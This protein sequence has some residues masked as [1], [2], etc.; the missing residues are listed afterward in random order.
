[1]TNT[2]ASSAAG[3][4]RHRVR[5]RKVQNSSLD[6]FVMGHK[7]GTTFGNILLRRYLQ[8]TKWVTNSIS[9]AAMEKFRA[10][11]EIFKKYAAQYDFDF[12]MLA[13][14]GYQESML[15]QAMISR[16]GAP[17]QHSRCH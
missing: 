16:R 3:R 8:N 6:R 10:T 9:G 14:Q 5:P 4:A 12:L 13:A 11:A 17:Y 7:E 15:N 1:M 2:S